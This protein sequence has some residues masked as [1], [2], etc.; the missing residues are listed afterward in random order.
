M[1]LLKRGVLTVLLLGLSGV[2]TPVDARRPKKHSVEERMEVFSDV[3]AA[4]EQGQQALAAD[5]LLQIIEDPK[6]NYYHV[7]AYAQL[8]G[9]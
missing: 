9:I 1:T 6:H 3:F 8:G 4:I 7:D 2:F 5:H